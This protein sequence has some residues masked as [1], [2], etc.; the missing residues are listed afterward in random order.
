[1]TQI[2]RMFE[3]EKED[4]VN[5]AVNNAVRETTQNNLFKYV[6]DGVMSMDYAAIQANMTVENFSKAME[7]HGY[8]VPQLA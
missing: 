8:R 4:A 1:M 7:E 6:N 5:N 3:Q 2:G